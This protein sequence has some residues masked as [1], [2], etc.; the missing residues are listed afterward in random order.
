MIDYG[1]NGRMNVVETQEVV[2]TVENILEYVESRFEHL[3]TQKRHEDIK[4]LASEFWEWG[5]AENT[6]EYHYICLPRL[7]E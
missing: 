1:D 4:A 3:E 5:A 6:E 7:A 2:T